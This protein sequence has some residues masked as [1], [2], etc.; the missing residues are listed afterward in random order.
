MGY[1]LRDTDSCQGTTG[2]PLYKFVGGRAYIV[3][4]VSRGNDCAKINQPGIYTDVTKYKDWIL[5]HTQDGSC[6]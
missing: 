2:G 6:N 1:Y 4:V 3:G 5:E